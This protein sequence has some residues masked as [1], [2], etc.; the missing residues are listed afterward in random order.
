MKRRAFTLLELLVAVAISS[1]LAVGMFALLNAGMIL[2]AKNLSLN[3]TSNSMRTALDR[4]EHEVQ[5]C[6]TTD[7][8]SVPQLINTS[9]AVVTT[10][11][12]AGVQF[13]RAIGSPYVV[14]VTGGTI[15][16]STTSLTLTRSKHPLASPPIPQPGDIVR[17]ALTDAAM[18]PRIQSKNV[19]TVDA[20]LR[21]PCTVTFEAA[22]VDVFLIAT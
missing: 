7:A 4:V 12:A 5:L 9:G 19:G 16:S 17:I 22:L 1:I 10:G 6:D 14:T 2:S 11:P 3:L 13:D 20:Q 21:E 15:P 18:R 8:T